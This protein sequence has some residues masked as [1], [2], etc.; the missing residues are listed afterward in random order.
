[1]TTRT[2][3]RWTWARDVTSYRK[4]SRDAAKRDRTLRQLL[5]E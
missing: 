2:A 1:M 4:L 5:G 3:S